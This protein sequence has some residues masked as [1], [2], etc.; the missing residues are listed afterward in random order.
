LNP[1]GASITVFQKESLFKGDPLV[2]IFPVVDINPS[3]SSDVP[4]FYSP[5]IDFDPHPQYAYFIHRSFSFTDQ[6][7]TTLPMVRVVNPGSA[8][9]TLATP[10][11]VAVAPYSAVAV[12]FAVPSPGN[13]FPFGNGLDLGG[14]TTCCAV[15]NS[16]LYCVFDDYLNAAGQPS[17]TPDRVGLNWYQIDLTGDSTGSGKGVENPTTVPALVQTS[18][19]YDSAL[20]N[21]K[22]YFMGSISVNRLGDVA[23]TGTEAGQ[24][25]Y[26]NVFYAARK[27]KDP[28]NTLRN[29]VLVTNNT[30]NSYNF[31]L[32]NANGGGQRWGDYSSVFVDPCND[33]NFWISGMW[34]GLQDGWSIQ[35]TELIRTNK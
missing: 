19:L 33:A 29:P 31:G 16:Q 25:T 21:P 10:V 28:L 34:A 3:D 13:P 9:P 2:T 1:L 27:K 26:T 15:R 5:A 24:T 4:F 17:F 35:A 7:F 8:Q 14:I 32:L 23:I 30:T 20:T 11:A 12:S 22:N 6:L 18:L